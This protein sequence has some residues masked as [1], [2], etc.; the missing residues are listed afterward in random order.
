MIEPKPKKKRLLK[1]IKRTL[2]VL[3]SLF[4][5]LLFLLPPIAKYVIEKY[6]TKFV[7]REVTMDLP[8]INPLTGY[9]SLNNLKMF[10]E[11]SDSIFFS[12][13][14]LAV[15]IEMWSLFKKEYKTSSISIDKPYVKIIQVDSTFNF[16]DI[17]TH[18][19][20]DST[21]EK[22]KKDTFWELSNV[23][24]TAG[25]F[26]YQADAIP[27]TLDIIDFEFLAETIGGEN[28]TIASQF[29]FNSGLSHGSV[30]GK[31]RM[32]LDSLA[33]KMMV[34]VDTFDLGFLENYVANIANFAHVSG[35]LTAQ[36]NAVGN[37]KNAKDI[38]TSGNIS[39]DDFHA[40]KAKDDDYIAFNR[41]HITYKQISPLKEIYDIDS[42]CLDAP[43]F[44][45]EK[46][47]DLDNIQAMFGEGGEKASSQKSNSSNPNFLFSIAK[48]VAALS[49]N[50][51]RSNFNVKK[52]E[53][54]NG[55]FVYNDFSTPEKFSV[56]T[57]SLSLNV[58]S[59][60]K[61]K[62]WVDF[63]LKSDI[64]PYGDL[65]LKLRMNPNDAK[66]FK[67][68][69]KLKGV[70]ASMLNPYLLAASSFPLDRGTIEVDGAWRVNNGEI[71]STNNLLVIDPR[72]GQRQIMNGAK[73]LPIR[74][75]MFFVRERGNVIDYEIPIKGNLNNPD[76]KFA[77]VIF[78]ILE[79][80][81]IKPATPFYNHK[82]KTVEQE[83]EKSFALKMEWK[84]ARLMKNEV[85][86]IHYIADYLRDN[87]DAEIKVEYFPY[88]EKE[89]QYIAFFEA[90]KQ[91]YLA[92]G[93]LESVTTEDDSLYIDELD[94][95]DS[96][97][98]KYLKTKVSNSLIFT[99]HERSQALVGQSKINSI[100]KTLTEK[101]LTMMKNAFEYEGVSDQVKFD[102]TKHNIVPYDGFS[103]FKITYQGELPD[104][105]TMAYDEMNNL[106]SLRP[107]KKYKSKRKEIDT[108]KVE[109][110]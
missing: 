29:S 32:N 28:D 102:K 12:A 91:Y 73:W 96:L 37:F 78:D 58:D 74:L 18:F 82:V 52:I 94:V 90:K 83:I 1:F 57:K 59:I 15:N 33:F 22:P 72:I 99:N 85:K 3:V 36:L 60:S 7:G 26:V 46:F 45:Y 63:V 39:I 109:K 75:G 105:L 100:Y 103:F 86:F 62:D 17:I 55:N 30:R 108:K 106:N 88:V 48:Y 4:I 23:S 67:I 47:T 54:S 14:N 35:D 104:Y 27:I 95:H 24:I 97:F 44:V 34:R 65:Y 13:D 42:I 31:Y 53:I 49:T 21:K 110:P 9:I 68:D 92:K 79:N 16:A 25:H 8:Y 93:L 101:R 76:Y 51:F 41:F 71:V 50:F 84:E 38:S 64:K 11:N 70:A 107:R 5:L 43:Y 69:Y 6:D 61:K 2:I 89:R 81:F 40:G 98:T 87:P 56:A 20:K 77:D 19:A 10:E 80:I 66:D